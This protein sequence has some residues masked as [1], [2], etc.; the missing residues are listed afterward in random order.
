M[1]AIG[2]FVLVED[3]GVWLLLDQEQRTAG[4]LIPQ[5]DGS[6]RR[7][8]PDGGVTTVTIPADVADTDH[9]AY[10]ARQITGTG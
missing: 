2:R 5:P 6:W 7:R 10:A 3:K 9:T 8:V 1:T 4:T